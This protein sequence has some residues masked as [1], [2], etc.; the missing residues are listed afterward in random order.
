VLLLPCNPENT[1]FSLEDTM[2]APYARCM[3]PALN[4]T[5]MAGAGSRPS[6]DNVPV[7]LPPGRVMLTVESVLVARDEGTGL[8]TRVILSPVSLR[9]PA[10]SEEPYCVSTGRLEARITEAVRSRLAAG[11]PPA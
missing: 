10:G 5:A 7:S 4:R 1:S 3:V 6:T 9:S 2:R 8:R 11:V